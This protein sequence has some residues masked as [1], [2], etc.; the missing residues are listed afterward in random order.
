MSHFPCV[1]NG[2]WVLKCAVL[3]EGIQNNN[4]KTIIYFIT[5]FPSFTSDF[6]PITSYLQI[7][8]FHKYFLGIID[9]HE[10]HPVCQILANKEEWYIKRNVSN[11]RQLHHM[12]CKINSTFTFRWIQ[13]QDIYLIISASATYLQPLICGAMERAFRPWFNIVA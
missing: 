10:I 9:V 5:S 13:N 8:Y 2:I 12:L 1:T 6:H 3:R 4:M 11:L 7:S